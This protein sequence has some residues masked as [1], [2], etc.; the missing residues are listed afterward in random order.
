MKDNKSI[1][2]VGNCYYNHFYLSRELRKLGWRADTL[3]IDLDP[4]SQMYYHGSDF[5]IRKGNIIGVIINLVF[6]VKAIFK[7][8][9]IHLEILLKRWI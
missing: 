8:K 3:N 6:F 9:K 7:Y 1:L 2:F 4:A 5:V